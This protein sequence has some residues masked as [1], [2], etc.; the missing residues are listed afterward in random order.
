MS[1]TDEPSP[2]GPAEPAP[3]A[4]G[5]YLASAMH[6][7]RDKTVGYWIIA[8]IVLIVAEASSPYLYD[9]LSLTNV[10]SLFFQM[11]LDWGPRPAE[12]RQIEIVRIEDDEY[13]EGELA[14]RRP[15]KRDYLANLV[16]RLVSLNAHVIALDFDVRLPK[17]DSA[18]IPQDYRSETLLFANAIKAAARQ[19]KKSCWQRRY[20]PLTKNHTVKTGTSITPMVFA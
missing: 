20:P 1:L 4:H 19:G 5:G 7:L 6:R 10:R 3:T 2:Q 13:W 9:Y 18:E 12:P 14:G 15:I 16:S 11:L 8:I 17:P